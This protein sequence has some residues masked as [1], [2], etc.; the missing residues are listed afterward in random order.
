[1]VANQLKNEE[2]G[3]QKT[4]QSNNR[5]EDGQTNKKWVAII[6]DI[7]RQLYKKVVPKTKTIFFFFAKLFLGLGTETLKKSVKC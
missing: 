1:M 3:K 4:R 5:Q 7:G 2:Q 6:F